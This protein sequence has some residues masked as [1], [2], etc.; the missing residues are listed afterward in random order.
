MAPVPVAAAT[1]S[2]AT[3]MTRTFHFF[4]EDGYQEQIVEPDLVVGVFTETIAPVDP[5]KEYLETVLS[6]AFAL[7]RGLPLPS[8][9]EPSN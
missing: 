3:D 2:F 5:A 6:S 1:T 9:W 8:T 7:R 4:A